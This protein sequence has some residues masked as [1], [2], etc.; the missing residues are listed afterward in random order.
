MYNED[1][2]GS[3][4]P[5]VLERV[6]SQTLHIADKGAARLSVYGAFTSQ[7]WAWAWQNA[8][9]DI[10]RGLLEN[11]YNKPW[12]STISKV[13]CAVRSCVDW[14]LYGPKTTEDRERCALW[15]LL[16]KFE[17]SEWQEE[18]QD[19]NDEGICSKTNR[20]ENT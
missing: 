2:R 17:R 6:L 16:E 8:M 12:E 9:G 20:R 15:G 3:D 14:G 4:V 11:S 13:M 7:D 1:L 5:L 19:N 10:V 18:E